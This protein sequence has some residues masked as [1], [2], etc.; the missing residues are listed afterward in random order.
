MMDM[1]RDGR[2]REPEGRIVFISLRLCSYLEWI[3]GN[4][5]LS[6]DAE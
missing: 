2:K 6:F 3:T 4:S 5:S 1:W